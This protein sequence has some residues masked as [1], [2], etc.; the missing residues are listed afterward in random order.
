MVLNINKAEAVYLDDLLRAQMSS[1]ASDILFK[2]ATAKRGNV[3]GLGG[4]H[5]QTEAGNLE[6]RPPGVLAQPQQGKLV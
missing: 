2:L 4:E 6:E 1:H 3:K 5:K